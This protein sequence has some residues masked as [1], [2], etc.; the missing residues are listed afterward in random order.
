MIISLLFEFT[1][2]WLL[3]TDWLYVSKFIHTLCIHRYYLHIGCVRMQKMWNV[4]HS[5]TALLGEGAF[6]FLDNRVCRNVFNK[7]YITWSFKPAFREAFQI[8]K[9]TSE[10]CQ[11]LKLTFRGSNLKPSFGA[12]HILKLTLGGGLDFE[13][14][15]WRAFLILK[16]AFKGTIS[17]FKIYFKGDISHWN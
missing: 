14:Y 16:P 9:P 13:T 17:H 8:L 7:H 11:V 15:F 12:F 1:I 4:F 3:K 5:N 10:A 2:L 6:H